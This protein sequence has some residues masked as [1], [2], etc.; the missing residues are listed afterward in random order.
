MA[1]CFYQ[2]GILVKS[3]VMRTFGFAAGA[4]ALEL[5]V[6][7]SGQLSADVSA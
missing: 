6:A 4:D 1:S 7:G 2:I 5:T 3:Q